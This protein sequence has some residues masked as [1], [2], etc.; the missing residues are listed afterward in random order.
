MGKIQITSVAWSADRKSVY[1]SGP[2]K[3]EPTVDT[4]KWSVDTSYVEKLVEDCGF[5]THAD[6]GGK[7]LIG[8]LFLTEK[9]GIYEVSISDG[10]CIPLLFGIVTFG[11]TF[12]PDGK[13]FLYAVGASDEV[14]I[15]RQTWNEGKLKGTP[16]TAL[17]VPFRFPVAYHG[18]NSYDFSR[19]LS[20]IVYAR[21]GGHADLYL[22]SQ[23]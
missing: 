5:I 16:Q 2:G 11:G 1:V 21:P 3:V 10:K 7:Y 8:S 9:T 4:L 6:P 12:A 17:K 18:G 15:Y 19:D 22:Q 23:K 20:T 14:T 13:S